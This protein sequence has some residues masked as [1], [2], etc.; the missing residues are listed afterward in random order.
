[1]V[2]DE[3]VSIEPPLA[4]LEVPEITRTIAGERYHFSAK[5]FF[6]INHH[7]LPALVQDALGDERG[8]TAIDLYCG[9]GLF[10]IP[11]ARRFANVI[12]VEGNER[13]TRFAKK[14]LES[15]GLN[16]VQIFTAD[17]GNWI[18]NHEAAGKP[19]LLLLDPPRTG[20]ENKVISGILSL[21]P[22]RIVYVS[23]DP[24]TLARDLKKLL[25]GGYSLDTV[26]AFDMFPQTHHVE[27]VVRLLA[28]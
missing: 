9:V 4:G 1:V 21:Q 6:Q 27:T 3:G 17:V 11:L 8:H 18:A 23:C 28:A 19:D 16:N 10:T 7:L 26:N 5:S 15:A 14:N 22:S 20:A 12:G 25:A 2:G 24:A 13:A